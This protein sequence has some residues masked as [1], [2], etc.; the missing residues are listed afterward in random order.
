MHA[1]R[2]SGLT[3]RDS[4]RF[5]QSLQRHRLAEAALY[6]FALCKALD[7]VFSNGGFHSGI[8]SAGLGIGGK[9][10]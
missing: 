6:V 3:F 4:C 7:L 10:G 5:Q 1:L 8:G 9:A 2:V